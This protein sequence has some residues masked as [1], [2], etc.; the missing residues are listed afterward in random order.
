MARR[1]KFI[2]L[3]T[4]VRIQI[5]GMEDRYRSRVVGLDPGR[6][7]ILT[8]PVALSPAIVQ[9]SLV[10]GSELLV[11][12]LYDGTVW[13]FRS[14]LIQV[15]SGNVQ[16]IFVEYP[17][18]IE[19]YEL[20]KA[21]RIETYLPC[22]L[23]QG[24]I[25]VDAILL[26]LSEAGARVSYKSDLEI[27]RNPGCEVQLQIP[28]LKCGDTALLAGVV[29]TVREREGRWVLGLQFSEGQDEMRQKVREY[30]DRLRDFLDPEEAP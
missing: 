6:F 28:A 21:E 26:D 16:V 1:G 15:L 22:R 19:N 9:T 23:S 4:E 29:R 17:E 11:R 24:D 14:R 30:L 12:Y 5:P 2:S 25:A 20:R 18:E 3:G 10:P 7:I 13:G 8:K 27:G